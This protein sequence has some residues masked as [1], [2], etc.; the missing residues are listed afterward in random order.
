MYLVRLHDASGRARPGPLGPFVKVT[1]LGGRVYGVSPDAKFA[2]ELGEVN[3]DGSWQVGV[4]TLFPYREL[5]DRDAL[6]ALYEWRR[7]NRLDIWTGKR[8]DEKLGKK[9]QPRGQMA[10]LIAKIVAT[11][12][13]AR[14]KEEDDED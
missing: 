4:E 12:R 2:D 3:P 5:A 6:P 7:R 8:L 10:A 9:E 13:R 1:I 14:R 11:A